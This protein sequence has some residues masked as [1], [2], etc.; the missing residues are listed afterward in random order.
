MFMT[1]T[2]F[3]FALAASG[4]SVLQSV[5][6]DYRQSQ[7][8]PGI[9]AVIVS[10]DKVKFSG[11]SGV[12]DLKSATPMSA[13]S[14]LYIGSVSKVLTAVLV[15]QLVE[16]GKLSLSTPIADVGLDRVTDHTPIS[17]AHLLSHS[18]GLDREGD[19]GY[20]FTA[21]FP[22][23][24]A[25]VTY[26][27]GTRLRSEPG[28]SLHYSNIGYAVLGQLAERATGESYSEAL[29][30]RVLKPLSMTAS[31]ARGP[32]AGA[33]MGYTPV[34]RVL[35]GRERPF[36]GVGELVGNRHERSYHD[37]R[38]MSP[39]F[40]AYA[41]ANDMGKLLLFLLGTGGDD[42]LSIRMRERLFERQRSGRGLG[43]RIAQIDG[44]RVARHDGW[45]AAH[46][47]HVLLDI[48][49]KLAVAV[50]ANSDNASTGE[51][52]EALLE[53]ALRVD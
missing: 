52:A 13:D 47:S 49:N 1:D 23:D 45:F 8:I 51:I 6:D 11:A 32:A 39:A 16:S 17:V 27:N 50:M 14:V 15:L 26:L 12:A 30:D 7:D 5:I 25:L 33:V 43:L 3:V 48:E 2:F 29:G 42:V 35:P 20:W 24:T 40:G 53:A 36:A 31:G 10:D 37:A 22:D 4:S 44:R 41:S 28:T 9:S 21:D 46:R 18:A 38:A 34:G 19:F